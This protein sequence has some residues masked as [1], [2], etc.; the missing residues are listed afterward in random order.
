MSQH[1]V[2]ETFYLFF[3]KNTFALNFF[4]TLHRSSIF[5]FLFVKEIILFPD[6]KKKKIKI[7]M[8]GLYL[9]NPLFFN[10]FQDEPFRGCLWMG[11]KK[12]PSLK[13]ITH[14]LQW[15]NLM[16]QLYL[17]KMKFKKYINHVTHHLSSADISPFPPQISNF[18]YIDIYLLDIHYI[19]IHNFLFLNIISKY[20]L[21]L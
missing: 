16:A 4:S 14:I 6:L 5:S 19:L 3:G 12:A 18:C 17:T 7:K 20:F 10:P 21:S 2:S 1:S 15:W 8:I 13:S 11:G 9:E